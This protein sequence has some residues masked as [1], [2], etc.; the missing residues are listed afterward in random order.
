MVEIASRGET[1]G[2]KEEFATFL[3]VAPAFHA[4]APGV[5]ELIAETTLRRR[6]EGEGYELRCP[7]EYEA[8]IGE[9]RRGFATLLDLSALPCPAKVIGADP[10]LP[11]AYL[12]THD[13]REAIVVGYDF[14]SE[15]THFLQLEKPGECAALVR[16]FVQEHHAK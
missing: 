7:R 11:S 2:T 14:L 16:A 8:Q 1:F 9:Y 13:L 4:I 15:A 3:G 12:P 10:T 6:S 5:R